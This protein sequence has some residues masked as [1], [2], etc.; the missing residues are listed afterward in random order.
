MAR[1]EVDGVGI[2]YDIVGDGKR[3]AVIIPGGRLSKDTPGV[4]ELAQTLAQGGL[5][6][7]IWD[8]P[9][10]GESDLCFTGK[11][12]S[13]MHADT[14]AGLLRAL[15]FPPSLIV[16][17][18][19]GSR[20]ALLVAIHHPEVVERLFAFWITGGLLTLAGLAFTYYFDSMSAAALSGMQA[21]ADLPTWREQIER[22][23]DNRQRFL[24]QDTAAFIEK[25]EAW[26]AAFLADQS[27]PVPGLVPAELAAL[28]MPVMVLRNGRLDV[29]HPRKVSDAV[30]AMIPGART[31]D[32]P[33]GDREWHDRMEV[34]AATGEGWY[35]RWPL[36]AP[37]ILEFANS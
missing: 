28:K 17:G 35:A 6:T 27:G 24:R 12:E 11:S 21:V 2:A 32:P 8:R 26:G 13:R 18:S 36:L 19:G 5:R 10:C 33:W 29:F 16:G 9:N 4:R 22:N 34:K 31:A 25:M 37:Q 20:T 1:I 3:A 14:L 23:P 7:L 30:H 15:D